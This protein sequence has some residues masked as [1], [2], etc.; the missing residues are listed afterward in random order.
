MYE[1][2][3]LGFPRHARRLILDALMCGILNLSSGLSRSGFS[4]CVRAF[5]QTSRHS[6]RVFTSPI[7]WNVM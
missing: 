3:L 4:N 1:L 5:V 7:L 6:L 2:I